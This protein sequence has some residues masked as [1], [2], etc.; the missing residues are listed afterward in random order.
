MLA[1]VQL[2]SQGKAP[3]SLGSVIGMAQYMLQVHLQKYCKSRRKGARLLATN[4]QRQEALESMPLIGQMMAEQKRHIGPDF[5]RGH[6]SSSTCMGCAALMGRC[7]C[8]T[9][10]S[11]VHERVATRSQRDKHAL[12]V[13]VWPDAPS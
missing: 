7:D 9:T 11:R 8:S 1:S 2:L 6:S 10:K 4:L 5:L 12:Q 13:H 3:L